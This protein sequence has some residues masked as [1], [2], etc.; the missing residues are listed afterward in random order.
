M[1]GAASQKN[2]EDFYYGK[3]KYIVMGRNDKSVLQDIV[4]EYKNVVLNHHNK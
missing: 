2:L 1:R 4:V 3:E